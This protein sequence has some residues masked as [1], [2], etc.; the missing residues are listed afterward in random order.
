M[1]GTALSCAT[2]RIS[3]HRASLS[4]P[5][6]AARAAARFGVD[7]SRQARRFQREVTLCRSSDEVTHHSIKKTTC[8]CAERLSRAVS[9]DDS[10]PQPRPPYSRNLRL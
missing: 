6:A 10:H 1:A 7:P 2:V 3:A 5:V 9:R 8:L 4:R